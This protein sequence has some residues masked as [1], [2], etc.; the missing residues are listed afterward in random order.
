MTQENRSATASAVAFKTA[1]AVLLLK[2]GLQQ[3]LNADRGLQPRSK[4]K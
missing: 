4:R 3:L 2:S 1:K